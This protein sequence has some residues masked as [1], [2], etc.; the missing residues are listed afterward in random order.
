M[1]QPQIASLLP[2]T[3]YTL[4]L[5]CNI[6]GF[7]PCKCCESSPKLAQPCTT[8]NRV[9]QK[10]PATWD[11]LVVTEE[12]HKQMLFHCG[13]CVRAFVGVK[14]I[15]SKVSSLQTAPCWCLIPLTHRGCCCQLQVPT[16]RPTER[17]S[18]KKW[19]QILLFLNVVLLSLISRWKTANTRISGDGR[20]TPWTLSL[21]KLTVKA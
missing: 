15:R 21:L 16:A 5:L 11:S 20:I 14:E 18:S 9:Y 12:F 19:L 8:C 3:A 4:V 6:S 10:L 2:A 13:V 7:D 1:N 17:S